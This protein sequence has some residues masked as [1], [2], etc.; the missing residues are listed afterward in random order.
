LNKPEA[1]LLVHKVD[2][3]RVILLGN[4]P[5]NLHK[6]LPKENSRKL[7]NHFF[8][9]TIKYSKN[10]KCTFILFTKSEAG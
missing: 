7:E 1:I 8:P 4:V 9:I 5:K 10:F 6:A 3:Y 2:R